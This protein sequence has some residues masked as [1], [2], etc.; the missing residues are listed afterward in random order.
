MPQLNRPWWRHK[1]LDF[2]GCFLFVIILIFLTGLGEQARFQSSFDN[3]EDCLF[4]SLIKKIISWLSTVHCLHHSFKQ[5]IFVGG[6]FLEKNCFV[7]NIMKSKKIRSEG[8]AADSLAASKKGKSG[9]SL[10]TCRRHGW[11]IIFEKS[12]MT[13]CTLKNEAAGMTTR[14]VS[15]RRHF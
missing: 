5:W 13:A 6:K 10:F 12:I 15:F 1:L 3:F 4:F 2:Q 8:A 9:L 14:W 7:T 11:E